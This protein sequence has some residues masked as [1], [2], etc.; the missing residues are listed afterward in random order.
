MRYCLFFLCSLKEESP[1]KRRS[2]LLR[3]HPF[4]LGI[5]LNTMKRMLDEL[6]PQ[7]ER[8]LNSLAS[9]CVTDEG[10]ASGEYL[11][12]V[13]LVLRAKFRGYLHAV[14][15]KLAE[16]VSI[17]QIQNTFLP[18]ALKQ[19]ALDRAASLSCFSYAD[20]GPKC[21]K[22]AEDN[23]GHEGSDGR[24]RNTEQNA[25]SEGFTDEHNPSSP[26]CP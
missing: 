19:T 1:F 5:L 9:S 11:S 2:F 20:K 12:E 22:I 13:T 14:V 15:E 26:P 23:T 7:I 25:A 24:F 8:K 3:D 18:L 6:M 16:N 17:L 10:L 4:Q 21:N